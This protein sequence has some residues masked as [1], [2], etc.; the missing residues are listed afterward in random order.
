MAKKL[1]VALRT[2][3]RPAQQ[4]NIELAVDFRAW[5]KRP[6]QPIRP[7]FR[8]DEI[9][10]GAPLDYFCRTT[11]GK[12]SNE[13]LRPAERFRFDSN[14]R[15]SCPGQW[16]S[17]INS[18]LPARCTIRAPCESNTEANRKVSRQPY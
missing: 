7:P 5:N 11:I 6:N 8:I 3:R 14:C 15:E 13:P 10:A 1:G 18:V 2:V 16:N 12:L 17:A 9:D 4:A